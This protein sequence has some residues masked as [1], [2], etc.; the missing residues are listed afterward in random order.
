VGK[1]FFTDEIPADGRVVLHGDAAKH[2]LH[3]LRLKPG[4]SVLLCNGKGTDYPAVLHEA[5]LQKNICLFI[6][7]ESVPCDTEMQIPIT[8]YQGLPKGDK[9]EWVIQKSVEL[10]VTRIVPVYTAH[11]LVKNAE[12]KVVRYQKI[13]L[14]AAEQSQRGIVPKVCTPCNFEA[15]VSLIMDGR[16]ET[17]NRRDAADKKETSTPNTTKRFP[18]RGLVAVSPSEVPEGAPLKLLRDYLSDYK[19]ASTK[20]EDNTS[21]PPLSIWV[22]PEG[23]FSAMEVKTLVTS[24]LVLVSLGKRILRTETAGPALLAQI[25]C[26]ME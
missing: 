12:K 23:G 8:L 10:G 20:P 3:V 17:A 21:F 15:A 2:L 9:M 16:Y 14:S 7:G 19:G 5:D 13:A 1:Y 24:G 22:G 25:Q 6:T 18:L 26:L 11:S 4:A